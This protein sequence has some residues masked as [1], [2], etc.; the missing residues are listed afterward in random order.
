MTDARHAIEALDDLP[1][2]REAAQRMLQAVLAREPE[3]TPFGYG[4]DRR[5]E[6]SSDYERRF[7]QARGKFDLRQF[8]TAYLF[9]MKL[10]KTQ[11][12]R[13]RMHSYWLKHVCEREARSYVTNGH[14]VAGAI[15]AGFTATRRDDGPNCLFNM[16]ERP[17]RPRAARPA[18]GARAEAA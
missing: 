9:C 17:P 11:T 13:P 12:A 1:I 8:A 7:A 4:L 6:T 15:A 3:L 18:C 2:S 16:S 5:A 10:F 14:F